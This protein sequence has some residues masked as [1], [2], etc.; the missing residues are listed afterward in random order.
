MRT[1]KGL[2]FP[3]NADYAKFKDG[4]I[5]NETDT[6]AG[7]PVIEEVYGDLLVNIY[8]L[9]EITGVIPNQTQDS[10]TTQF[11]LVEALQKLFN[12]TN[13]VEQILT[14]NGT[15]WSVPFAINLLPDKFVFVARASESYNSGVSYTFTGSDTQIYPLT[16]PSGFSSGDELLCIID[17]NGVRIYSLS[18]LSNPNNGVFTVFGIPLAFNN[19]AKLYYE[20]EG[21]LFAD[22]PQI[23]YLQQLIR[24][25]A[26]DGQL[27]VYDMVILKGHVLCLVYDPANNTY[28]FFQF[29]LNDLN[30]PVEVTVNGVVIPVGVDREPYL[31]TDG[32]SLYLTNSSGNSDNDYDLDRL[33]YTPAGPS[34]DFAEDLTLENTYIKSSNTVIHGGNLVVFSNGDLFRFNLTTGVRTIIGQ[35]NSLNGVIFK[36]NGVVY[37]SNGEV[38]KQWNV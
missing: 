6:E 17:Q 36:F 26:G 11:Q 19:T 2:P 37:Y 21:S 28:R 12:T 9:L 23:F 16:S 31:F 20:S 25:A 32:T 27:T 35:F 18:F 5:R 14:L 10:E 3:H 13:D 34:I 38:A 4:T 33:G 30:T 8:K 1:L 22:D 29:D 15:E 7:T 24:V